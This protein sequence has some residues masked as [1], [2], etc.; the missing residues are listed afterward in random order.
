[1]PNGTDEGNSGKK[2]NKG[3]RKSNASD[4]RYPEDLRDI[5]VNKPSGSINVNRRLDIILQRMVEADRDI[6]RPP[7]TPKRRLPKITRMT[8]SRQARALKG[9]PS[10]IRA[11]YQTPEQASRTNPTDES[12][13]KVK[14][15]REVGPGDRYNSDYPCHGKETG[16]RG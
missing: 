12:S 9:T 3:A 4:T 15:T 10:M 6:R 5:N 13:R 1:M 11:I 2:R 8:S 14:K 16:S 7:V